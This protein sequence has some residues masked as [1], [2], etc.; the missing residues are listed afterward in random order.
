MTNLDELTESPESR[1]IAQRA[2]GDIDGAI[3]TLLAA[4]ETSLA[5]VSLVVTLGQMLA[6]TGQPERAERWLK[7]AMKL[8]PD[9]LYARMTFGTFVG[10]TGRIAESLQLLGGVRAEVREMLAA[11]GYDESAQTYDVESFLA[12]AEVN[13][14]R[15]VFESGD[16]DQA[17]ELARPWLTDLTYWG[18]AHNVVTDA[19]DGGEL[20]PAAFAAE[21]LASGQVSPFMVCHLL[22]LAVD[23]EPVDFVALDRLIARADACFDFDWQDVEPSIGAVMRRAQE[24]FAHAVMRGEVEAA[25]CPELSALIATADSDSPALDDDWLDEIDWESI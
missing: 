24:L 18:C 25:A 21:A 15:A 16:A 4:A 12:C 20:D 7:H 13:L 3:Q 5:D 14:A 23:A 1:A 11:P 10:Q 2:D 9:D 22:E 8:A 19:V 17:I 6:E